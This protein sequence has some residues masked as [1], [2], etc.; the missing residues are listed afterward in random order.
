MRVDQIL[1]NLENVTKTSDHSWMAC[2]PIHDDK[3]PSLCITEKDSVVLIHCFGCGCNGVDICEHLNIPA[4]NL[5]PTSHSSNFQSNN[6]R[7]YFPARDVL[8][9][10]AEDLLIVEITLNEVLETAKDTEGLA[11]HQNTLSQIHDRFSTAAS[12]V[13]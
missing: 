5:F 2:C 8:N 11:Q 9:A 4:S 7:N 10:L 12:Y 13:K 3:T 1:T 6:S